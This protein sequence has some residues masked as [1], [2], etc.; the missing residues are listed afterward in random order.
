ML[1]VSRWEAFLGEHGRR[2][3]LGEFR[4]IRKPTQILRLP[5]GLTVLFHHRVGKITSAISITCVL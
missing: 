3:W 4:R 2:G 1:G 5:V